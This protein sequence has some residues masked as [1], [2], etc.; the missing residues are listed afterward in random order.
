MILFIFNLLTDCLGLSYL[1][2]CDEIW[3]VVD[4]MSDVRL[5][6]FCFCLSLVVFR[7]VVRDW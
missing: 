1:C 2:F 7:L 3:H 4:C 5:A 6:L